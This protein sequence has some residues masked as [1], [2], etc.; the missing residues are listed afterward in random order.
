MRLASRDE[1]DCCLGVHD[2]KLLQLGAEAD[3]EVKFRLDDAGLSHMKVLGFDVLL[4][5]QVVFCNDVVHTSG[6]EL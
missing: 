1:N 4:C 6:K 2:A 3:D 5:V